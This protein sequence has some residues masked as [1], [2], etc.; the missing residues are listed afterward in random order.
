MLQQLLQNVVQAYWGSAN[1]TMGFTPAS[2]VGFTS[3]K[4][5]QMA[6]GAEG[7]IALEQEVVV[8]EREERMTRSCNVWS[9]W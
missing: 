5:L 2:V 4:T 9:Y 1:E 7:I 6:T 3:H 8:V